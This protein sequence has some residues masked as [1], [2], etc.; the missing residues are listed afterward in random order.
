MK[1]VNQDLQKA[2]ELYNKA[3]SNGYPYANRA[4]TNILKNKI[5]LFFKYC[6]CK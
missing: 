1:G 3:E 6:V 4:I 5:L 2:L